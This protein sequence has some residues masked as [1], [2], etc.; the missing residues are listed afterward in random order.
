VKPKGF[1]A[2]F[3]VPEFS[4][5]LTAKGSIKGDVKRP[6]LTIWQMPLIWEKGF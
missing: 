2:F 3:S 4:G 5:S 1:N 6:K